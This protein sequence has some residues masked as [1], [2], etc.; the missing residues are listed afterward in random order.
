[1]GG[2]RRGGRLGRALAVAAV[3]LLPV[4]QPALA[5]ARIVS[6]VPAAGSTWTE[7]PTRVRVEYSGPVIARMSTLALLDG[8]GRQ[9]RGTRLA[10]EGDRTLV[11]SVPPLRLPPGRSTF[12]VDSQVVGQDLDVSREQFAF[13]V[14]VGPPGAAAPRGQPVSWP[15]VALVAVG[16][17]ALVALLVRRKQRAA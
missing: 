4:G 14:Q 5:A 1:M 16:V 6:S 3:L 17:G 8:R 2:G 10:S 9:V 12:Y 7:M 15:L 11:L 13:Y